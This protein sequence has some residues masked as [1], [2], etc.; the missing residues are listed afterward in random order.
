MKID[1]WVNKSASKNRLSREFPQDWDEEKKTEARRKTIE[2]LTG[3]DL[4]GISL[5]KRVLDKASGRNIEQAIGVVSV[6]LGIAGP[7]S[8]K[9]IKG[10]IKNYFVPIATTEGALAASLN[11]GSRAIYESGGALVFVE[12]AGTTR[13]PVFRTKNLLESKRL[14]DWVL[15]HQEEIAKVGAKT[16]KHLKLISMEPRMAGKNM[17]L[18]LGFDTQ[19]AMGMNMATIASEAIAR[20]LEKKTGA[21]CVSLSG[22]VCVDKKPAS[23]NYILGRGKKVWA[24]V[25]LSKKVL[26]E[27][28]KT[29]ADEMVEVGYRKILLGSALAG[30]NGFNAQYANVVAAIFLATGQDA[31]HVVEGSAGITTVEKEAEGVRV[32]VYLPSVLAGTVGG[33]TSLPSQRKALEILGLGKGKAGEARELAKIIGGA[34]LAGEISLTASLAEGSLAQAHRRLGRK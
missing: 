6:P 11:R 26:S 4:E 20:F 15:V 18:R 2:K 3:V 24:E 32:S 21:C 22:N 34:V 23:L 31:A 19:E 8:I 30:S 10:K 29:S 17:F 14:A 25:L 27:I 33:G 5:G 16:S 13:A 9:N 1:D 28:L 7:L 12:E